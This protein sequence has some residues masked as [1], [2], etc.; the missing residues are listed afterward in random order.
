MGVEFSVKNSRHEVTCDLEDAKSVISF[1]VKDRRNTTN[2]GHY[3]HYKRYKYFQLP[4]KI[5]AKL[6]SVP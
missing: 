2:P 4:A 5:K 3:I 1:K 6:K